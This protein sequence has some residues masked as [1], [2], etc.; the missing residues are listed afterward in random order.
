MAK[1]PVTEGVS[2][3]LNVNNLFDRNYIDLIH[4]SH[5]VPGEG[6]AAL[7]SLNAKF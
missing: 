5:V 2:V 7:F 4:P 1:M 3:Q 6:R